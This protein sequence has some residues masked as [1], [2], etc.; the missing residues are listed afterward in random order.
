MMGNKKEKVILAAILIASGLVALGS[1]VGVYMLQ[2]KAGVL[3]TEN[4]ALQSRVAQAQTK[5]NKLGALKTQREEAE[6]RLIVAES[7]LPSQEEIENLVDSLSEFARKSGVVIAKA[8]PVRTGAYGGARGVVKRFEE[9]NF[10]LKVEGD[11]FQL[12]EFL[13]HLENY[14]RFIR[15]DGF[16]IKSGRDEIAPLDVDLKFATFSYMGTPAAKGGRE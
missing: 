9:T 13:N 11:F 7:I 6:A 16:I 8:A 1:G 4:V 12:V 3:E 14:K 2:K 10:D 15:V 5:L